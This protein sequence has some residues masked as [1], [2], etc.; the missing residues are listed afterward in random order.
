MAILVP[1]VPQNETRNEIFPVF[2]VLVLS[3]PPAKKKEILLLFV[4]LHTLHRKID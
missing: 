3:P 4:S 1:G 2:I